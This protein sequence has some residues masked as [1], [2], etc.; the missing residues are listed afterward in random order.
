MNNRNSIY[1]CLLHIPV[2]VLSDRP[3]RPIYPISTRSS[4]S[5]SRRL[6][7]S[8]LGSARLSIDCFVVPTP[9]DFT[10]VQV[11]YLTNQW[12]AQGRRSARRCRCSSRSRRHSRCSI[13]AAATCA[14]R[15][16]A[17][18]RRLRSSQ[19]LRS[20]TWASK[21]RWSGC[22]I[23]PPPT[24]ANCGRH[25][26]DEQ[27]AHAGPS[28]GET[29]QLLKPLASTLEKL[30]LSYNELGGTLTEEISAYR[31]LAELRLSGMGIGGACV[32]R[33]VPSYSH[34]T[35]ANCDR[36]KI[37]KTMRAHDACALTTRLRTPHIAQATSRPR[38]VSSRT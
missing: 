26:S 16:R 34:P 29:L 35:E 33:Y 11:R 12:R 30:D 32:C 18:S 15:S 10:P 3:N 31:K 17:T 19:N 4:S 37:D 13:L 8:A 7:A 5:L 25:E 22:D 20:Q 36:S 21:A 9:A 6:C 1:W 27:I 24:K 14:V 2:L 23:I 28:L 38:L